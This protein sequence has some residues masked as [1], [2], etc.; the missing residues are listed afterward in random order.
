M[1]VKGYWSSRVSLMAIALSASAVSQTA[2]A[3]DAG[4]AS[5][6]SP[7]AIEDIVVTARKVAESQQSVPVSIT[8]FSQEGLER[9]AV[10]SVQDLQTA[11]P[12]LFV[13][14]NSQGGAPTFAIRA[15]K[16]DNGTSNTV[17][18]YIN[19][20]PTTTTLAVALMVYDMES[21]STLKGPQG[22]LFGANST[23]GA[24]IF[25]PKPPTDEFEGYIKG[26]LGNFNRRELEGVLN[27]P[28]GEAFQVRLAGNLVRRDGF[29]TNEASTAERGEASVDLSN[30]RHESFRFSARLA[31]SDT[32]Q[33]DLMVSYFNMDQNPQ[34]AIPV[35]LRGRYDYQT[36]LG[37]SVPVDYA[38]AG[39]SAAPDERH[40]RI[41]PDPTYAK[42]RIWDI[43]NTTTVQLSDNLTA[44]L[45]LGFEDADLDTFESSGA[46]VG[47]VVD[48][49]T[50]DQLRQFT[51]EPSVDYETSDG[52]FKIKVGGFYSDLDRK[53][54]NSYGVIG[55][56]F[57]L[58]A[59]P[60]GGIVPNYYP[61]ASISNYFRDL[62]SKAL[63]SQLSYKLTDTLT[64]TLGARYTWDKGRYKASNKTGLG[65]AN[66]DQYLGTFALDAPALPC[67]S[68]LATYKNFDP[69]ACTGEQD[70][71][72]SSPSFTAVLENQFSRTV[73]GYATVRT[74]YLVGGFNNQ[75]Y[76]PGGFAQVFKPEKV[77]DG[78][79]GVKADWCLAGQPIRTNFDIFAGRYRNQQRVQNGTT[80]TGQT[81]IAVQNAGKS[82]F[83]GT[84]V[85]IVYDLTD[86][87]QL[88]GS[89][90]WVHARY[91]EFE[92][93]LNIP[94]VTGAFVDF[95]GRAQ[96]QT[97]AH[98]L[99]ISGTYTLPL[100]ENLGKVS[101]TLTYFWR[102]STT[103]HDAPTVS[104]TVL[105]SG[106]L[107]QV[108]LDFSE[109][110]KLPSY[111]LANLSVNWNNVLG[112][113]FDLNFW[114]K[115]LFDKKY[116]VYQSNQLLQFGYAT[117]TYGSP[118][119][120]GANLRF[121]F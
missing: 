99:N 14:P 73:M 100:D 92:A 23:G 38:M 62:T 52:R 48:G 41:G 70:Y 25:R 47:T 104:G 80:S 87:F 68:G 24:I 43:T 91:D 88:R 65:Q 121:N 30:E 54:G 40:V 46:T 81:F 98:V 11:V 21:V 110:D 106:E 37:F 50:R 44:K 97:P 108:T 94:G 32:F 53:T 89:Y 7:G 60:A 26:G 82:H 63:Y 45:A 56:P 9:Q 101:A 85:E 34:Q 119:E 105:P 72:T 59:V 113:N 90:Q 2:W 107:D 66:V 102:S 112:S 22:T 117:Y 93:P 103:G 3:Q 75:V 79:I 115:N 51:V 42:A 28:F 118:R 1:R 49:R 111:G 57:D 13:A 35:Y 84:D 120:L 4:E 64:A 5:E 76:V 114:V 36:F 74:G 58:A 15:A 12:G 55:L 61:L 31:P 69:V 20:M 95:K 17:T 86:Q 77:L 96:S 83:Y 33:N 39:I 16:A 78:E 109:Y 8:A 116:A 27:I 10:L 18:T 67:S 29:V 6:R 19:D 71:K